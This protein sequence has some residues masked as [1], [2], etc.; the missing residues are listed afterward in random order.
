MVLGKHE[1]QKYQ[2]VP[3]DFT[4]K[5]TKQKLFSLYADIWRWVYTFDNELLSSACYRRHKYR[6]PGKKQFSYVYSEQAFF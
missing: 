6:S 4:V 1:L 3:K 5:A 2:R